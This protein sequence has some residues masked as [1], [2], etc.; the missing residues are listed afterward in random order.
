MRA[1]QHDRVCTP[2]NTLVDTS[3]RST[4]PTHPTEPPDRSRAADC[5]PEIAHGGA[6]TCLGNARSRGQRLTTFAI[7]DLVARL[8]EGVRAA[9]PEDV[10]LFIK[11]QTPG[12]FEAAFASL[13]QT[14]AAAPQGE[15]GGAHHQSFTP[16][17]CGARPPEA[18]WTEHKWLNVRVGC[19][20]VDA[21]VVRPCI[22][23]IEGH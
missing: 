6:A 14:R 3:G 4:W 8:E 15:S 2:T 7:E 23:S 20:G 18:V 9:C 16:V 19:T 12:R 1:G 11:P 13:W 17:R 5:A 21:M 10:A 22:S